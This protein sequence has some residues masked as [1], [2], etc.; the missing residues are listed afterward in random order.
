MLARLLQIMIIVQYSIVYVV[1]FG[2]PLSETMTWHVLS[3]SFGKLFWSTQRIPYNDILKTWYTWYTSLLKKSKYNLYVLL[4]HV[5]MYYNAITGLN[6]GYWR[7]T[8][9]WNEKIG[10]D[11]PLNYKFCNTKGK[12][13]IDIKLICSTCDRKKCIQ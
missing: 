12:G 8:Q 7:W 6:H 1:F 11:R 13:D 9:F 10:V 4:W 2:V 5:Y 3:S